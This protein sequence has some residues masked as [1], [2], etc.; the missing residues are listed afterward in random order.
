MSLLTPVAVAVALSAGCASNAPAG[1]SGSTPARDDAVSTGAAQPATMLVR[2]TGT[3]VADDE[4]PGC[5]LLDTGFT[6]YVLLGGDRAAI[7]A[8][9][10]DGEE[11]T[12]TGQA[13]T[14][15]PTPC[16]GGI[17]LAIERF[18]PAT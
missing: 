5:L 12:V 15:T 6:T 1:G 17:P 11:V 3:V 9:R 18:T 16:T 13:H 8:A 4:Q 7:E 14:P 10:D 2:V